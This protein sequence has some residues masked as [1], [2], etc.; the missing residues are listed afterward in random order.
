MENSTNPFGL[1]PS[2]FSQVIGVLEKFTEIKAAKI[3]GSRAKGN[4]QR[5]SDVDIAIFSD[6]NYQASNHQA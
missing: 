5:Y 4:Y 3:F 2:I 1:P 6:T